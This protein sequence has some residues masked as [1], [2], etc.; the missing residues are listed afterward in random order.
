VVAE[1]TAAVVAEATAAVV[2]EAT[3]AAVAEATAAVVVDAAAAA[4]AEIAA[5]AAT[6]TKSPKSTKSRGIQKDAPAFCCLC[7]SDA[8]C[9]AF[10]LPR[11]SLLN[12]ENM[13]LSFAEAR[14]IAVETIGSDCALYDEDTLKKPYGWLEIS[15]R[16]L[17]EAAA[18]LWKKPTGALCI[19][20]PAFLWRS[21]SYCTRPDMFRRKQRPFIKHV[22]AWR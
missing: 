15:A 17:L 2:A 4:G 10:F 12:V 21:R 20:V 6:V 8:A 1:A 16:C 22:M 13:M 11:P 5:A 3:A 7:R 9:C 18:S 19:S 14:A